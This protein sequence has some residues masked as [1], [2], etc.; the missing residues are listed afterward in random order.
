MIV[1]KG[2]AGLMTDINAGRLGSS[3]YFHLPVG[4]LDWHQWHAGAGSLELLFQGC[5]ME[6]R[7]TKKSDRWRGQHRNLA[8]SGMAAVAGLLGCL[9]FV[10]GANSQS[11]PQA[12]EGDP[13][14]GR[15]YAMGTCAQCHD[16]I[17]RTP[18]LSSTSHAPSFSAIAN[19][20][21]TSV[22]GLNAFLMTPHPT[23]PNLIIAAEDRRNVV[24]YIFSLRRGKKPSTSGT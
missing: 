4:R 10:G 17:A 23:M 2:K 19:E 16:V 1:I 13:V 5:S 15:S 8:R 14:S 6:I 12:S 24:A 3:R 11:V 7:M 9:L 22:I 21:T 18:P 20:K